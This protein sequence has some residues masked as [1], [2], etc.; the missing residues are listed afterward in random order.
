[1]S[2]LNKPGIV[3]FC[4]IWLEGIDTQVEWPQL[5]LGWLWLTPSSS[6]VCRCL[7]QIRNTLFTGVM[8]WPHAAGTVVMCREKVTEETGTEGQCT[9]K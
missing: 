1:M 7:L 3:Q 5:C 6:V 4:I 9:M 8:Q 2:L